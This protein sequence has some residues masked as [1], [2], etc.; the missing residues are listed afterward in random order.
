MADGQLY[1]ECCG[2][3]IRP[4]KSYGSEERTMSQKVAIGV[5]IVFHIALLAFFMLRTDKVT[6]APPPAREN[7]MV[8][9]APMSVLP[10]TPK[11]PPM[12]KTPPTP[13]PTQVAKSRPAPSKAAPKV[14]ATRPQPPKLEVF[15]PPVQSPTPRVLTPAPTDDMATMIA[16]RKAARGES[17]AQTQPEE[18]EN[19]RAMRVAKANIAAAQGKN[20]GDDRNDSGGVFSITNQTYH[21]A[22][23]KFR[24]WNGNF[25]RR[26]LQQITVEQG[27]EKDLE[28]A[29]VKKMIE[30]IRKEKPGD[31]VWESQRLGRNVN[32]SARPEDQAELEAFLIKEFFPNYKPTPGR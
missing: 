14:A 31:F 18:S 26:W 32:L 2:Q 1:C 11:T 7:A 15:T 13:K 5:S 9:V 20:S 28:T 4:P 22:D 17:Q 25:K 27:S 23:V 29:I 8:Y 10:P 16:Q 24:G 30:L 6:K 19:D 3:L 21:S 12:P